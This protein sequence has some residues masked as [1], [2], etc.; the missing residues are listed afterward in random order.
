MSFC[1]FVFTFW[2]TLSPS[3]LWLIDLYPYFIFMSDISDFL[4]MQLSLTNLGVYILLELAV[5]VSYLG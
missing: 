1:V 3:I 5:V 2:S 4:Q